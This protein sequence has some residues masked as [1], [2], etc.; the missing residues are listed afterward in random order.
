MNE[1][2]LRQ[3][4]R[5]FAESDLEELEVE[6][7]FWRGT[8]VRLSRHSR[9]QAAAHPAQVP[10]AGQSVEDGAAAPGPAIAEPSHAIASPMVGTFYRSS[11]PDTEPFV[12]EGD[13]VKVGQTVCIIEAMKIMNEIPSDVE[14]E[15]VE[16]L[17]ENA[18]PVEYGQPLVKVRT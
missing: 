14:G 10:A 7:S 13:H 5:I 16:I 9:R 6:H 18:T 17:I 2:K 11:S 3:L 4:L 12:R 1:A 15:V 8:R